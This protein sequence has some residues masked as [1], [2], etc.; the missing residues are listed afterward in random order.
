MKIK[1]GECYNN[2]VASKYLARARTNSLQIRE[3][4]GRSKESKKNKYDTTCQ[5]CGEEE[6][7]LEHF[8][9]RC[10]KLEPKRD[11][12]IMKE[13]DKMKKEKRVPHLL[14]KMKDYERVSEMIYKM[15]LL[16]KVLLKPP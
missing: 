14:F 2:S 7:N 10:K 13:L 5:I 8:L 4:Y 1:Y 12:E 15:W 6:E 16:R 11:E 9:I 3:V